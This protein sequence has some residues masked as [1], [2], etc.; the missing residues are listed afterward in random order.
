MLENAWT[1][2]AK[3]W[4]K[5]CEM[6]EDAGTIPLK[7]WKMLEQALWN[8]GNA[9]TGPVKCG[10][11]WNKP[12][13]MLENAWTILLKYWKMLEQTLGNAGNAGTG[14]VKCR[15]C[16]NKPCEMLNVP[17]IEIVLC[18][19]PSCQEIIL[20][21]IQRKWR[22]RYLFGITMQVNTPVFII[23]IVSIISL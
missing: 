17:Q 15:K 7:Y 5:P 6:L 19:P 16:W 11:C 12:F 20:C 8:A 4:N 10:K 1:S 21:N 3:C 14:P 9:G 23:I 22:P 13:E 2:P 18:L